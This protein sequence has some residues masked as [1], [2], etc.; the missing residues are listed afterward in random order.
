MTQTGELSERLR[1]NRNLWDTI[2]QMNLCVMG[3]WEGKDQEKRA[4]KR[5]EGIMDKMSFFGWEH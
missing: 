5:S 2:R 1:K 4:E 3:T